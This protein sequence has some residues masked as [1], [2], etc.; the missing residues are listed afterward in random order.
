MTAIDRNNKQNQFYRKQARLLMKVS[1]FR[2]FVTK[3]NRGKESLTYVTTQFLTLS[4]HV[5]PAREYTLTKESASSNRTKIML[6][7]NEKK[8]KKKYQLSKAKCSRSVNFLVVSIV[9]VG[10]MAIVAL[11]LEACRE[12]EF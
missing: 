2:E 11:H 12:S 8:K 9:K 4:P 6:C 10:T 1:K 3:I 5:F 7:K